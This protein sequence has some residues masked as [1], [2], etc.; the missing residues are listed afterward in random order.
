MSIA[1][2]IV[3]LPLGAAFVANIDMTAEQGGATTL[4]SVEHRKLLAAQSMVLPKRLAVLLDYVRKLKDG[5]FRCSR[6]HGA[7][8]MQRALSVE[9]LL[10][11]PE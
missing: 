6:W 10:V 8:R 11:W 2:G 7:P 1:T 3:G 5:A 4:D 9:V